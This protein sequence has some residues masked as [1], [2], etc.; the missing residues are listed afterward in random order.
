[1][2]KSGDARVQTRSSLKIVKHPS[3]PALALNAA[4]S[5]RPLLPSGAAGNGGQEE[6][7]ALGPRLRV[8]P[9]EPSSVLTGPTRPTPGSPLQH[10]EN[11]SQGRAKGS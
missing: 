7:R 6:L 11:R 1:M 5:S 2:I 4:A 9:G 10:R 3:P 8:S